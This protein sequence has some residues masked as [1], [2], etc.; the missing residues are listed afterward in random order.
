MIVRQKAT[1]PAD[2]IECG[3]MEANLIVTYDPTHAGKSQEEVKELLEEHGGAEF[4]ESGFEGVFLLHTKTD[5]KKIVKKLSDACKEEPYKFKHTFRWIPVDRW[6]DSKL[7]EMSKAMKDIDA[8]IGEHES[9]KLDL[10]KRGYEGDTMGLI[11]KLTE[12][13]NKPNVNL[14]SPDKIVKVEIVGDRAGIALLNADEYL[15]IAKMK[16]V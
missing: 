15:N 3:N 8:K 9:W 13:I 6:C 12:H 4:L 14:K 7:D 5:P 10:G 11:M 16:M 2:K 1:L